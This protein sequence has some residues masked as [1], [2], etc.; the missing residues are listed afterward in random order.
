MS[1]EGGEGGRGEVDIPRGSVSALLY[2]S[3]LP[4]SYSESVPLLC[5]WCAAL[6]EWYRLKKFRP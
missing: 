3:L 6:R 4:A 5:Q 1:E 2:I